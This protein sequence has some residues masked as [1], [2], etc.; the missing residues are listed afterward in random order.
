MKSDKLEDSDFFR[1]GGMKNIRGYREEQFLASVL[2]Y[3]NVE[4]RYSLARRSFMFGFY[5]FG[6]YL[7][8]SDDLNFIP[9]QK[10]FL[11]GYGIGIRLDTSLGIIGVSYALGKGD[12][13]LDGKIHFGLINEF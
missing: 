13:F 12:S 6:Y 2:I 3:S 5:D 11:Y 1:I 9:E 7:R 8:P 4:I 10:G